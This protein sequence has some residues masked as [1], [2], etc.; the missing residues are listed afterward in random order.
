MIL[1]ALCAV[2]YRQRSR[3]NAALREQRIIK[4]KLWRENAKNNA[5]GEHYAEN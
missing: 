2:E 3:K 5:K 4:R 1:S